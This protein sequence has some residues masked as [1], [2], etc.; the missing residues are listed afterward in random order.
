[1]AQ[2]SRG[3]WLSAIWQIPSECRKDNVMNRESRDLVN[4]AIV[5]MQ[6]AQRLLTLACESQ[7]E[8]Y[9]NLSDACQDGPKGEAITESQAALEDGI[10]N[11]ESAIEE[12]R[13]SLPAAKPAK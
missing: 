3:F 7:Q 13:D 12:A 5:M 6:E 8:A 9:E 1:M 2:A 4:R 10:N 11:L